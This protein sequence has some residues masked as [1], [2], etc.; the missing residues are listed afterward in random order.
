[1]NTSSIRL[2]LAGAACAALVLFP[3]SSRAQSSIENGK[4][5]GS[6]LTQQAQNEAAIALPSFAPLA[7]HVVPAV[8]NVSVEM[9]EQAAAQD[10]GYAQGSGGLVPSVPGGTPFDQFM[11][12]FFEN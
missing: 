9:T 10:E 11:R 6:N 7:E 4:Q 12:R 8:V 1:M 3:A 5:A 2:T